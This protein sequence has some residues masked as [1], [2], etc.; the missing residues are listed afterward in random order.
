MYARFTKK[1]IKIFLENIVKRRNFFDKALNY[2]KKIHNYF[3]LRYKNN[4]SNY[5][6]C[7]MA[8]KNSLIKYGID[9]NK[10]LVLPLGVESLKLDFTKRVGKNI[11]YIG[12]LT[13]T[14]NVE[15]LIKA[16]AQL[17][18]TDAK[19]TIAGPDY[20]ELPMLKNLVQKLKIENKVIFTGWISEKEKIDLLSKTSIFVHPSLEDIF[21][22][23]LAET[24]ASGVPV[25]A[26]GGTGT[27]EIIVD[28]VTGKVVKERTLESLRDAMDYILNNPDLI[29]KFSEN[30]RV[31]TTKKYNWLQTA[32]DLQN[33]YSRLI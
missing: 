8:E 15:L 29:N 10:I 32:S 17:D 28:M 11:T 21:S 19:L 23:S 20:G 30:G 26:F 7:S 13:K 5:P 31:L 3:M 12:R 1:F 22:L 14:K 2:L 6:A 18:N 9:E 27:S 4:V 24:S 16:F 25:I 33:L